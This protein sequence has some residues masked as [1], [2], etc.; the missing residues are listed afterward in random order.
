MNRVAD[1]SIPIEALVEDPV[2]AVERMAEAE[3]SLG[4]SHP[5]IAEPSSLYGAGRRNS[6]GLD[7]SNE[8]T[9]QSL[10]LALTESAGVRWTAQPMLS[11]AAPMVDAGWKPVRN[12]ANHLDIVGRCRAATE[13]EIESALK[14]ATEFAPSWAATSPAGRADCLERAA[15]LM[16]ARMPLL[17]GL[18]AREAGKTYSNGIA[19]VREAIDF[20]RF[21]AAQARNDFDNHAH[22]ALGPVVCISPWNFPLAIFVGQIAAAAAAGNTVLAKPAEQTSLIAAAGIGLLRE[23]GVPPAAVQLVTGRG[24][25]VG[26]RMIADART[27]GVMFTGST[28]VARHLQQTLAGRVGPTGDPIPLIAETGGQNAMLVDSS[29]LLEQVAADIVGSAFDSAGQRCSALRV[30]C[31]QDEIADSLIAM[32]RGEMAESDVGNPAMLRTDVGPVI[33]AGARRGIEDHIE[34]MRAKGR[35]VHRLGRH[36]R[37]VIEGGTYVLPT[38]IEL[39]SISELTKEVFG[40]V[41]HVVRFSRQNLLAMLDQVN[42][43]GYGLTMGLHTRIDETIERVVARARAGNLYINRNMVGAVVGVQPFGGEGLSGTGPKAGGPLYMYRLIAAT[44]QDVL[45]RALAV[46][47]PGSQPV[48]MNRRTPEV[49]GSLL[50][51]L[52]EHQAHR[53]AAQCR[54]FADLVGDCSERVLAGPTGERNV[55]SLHPRE[56]VFCMADST[57]GYLHALAAALAVGTQVIWEASSTTEALRANLPP[58]VQK[59]IVLAKDWLSSNVAFDVALHQGSESELKRVSALLARR[60]GPIVSLRRFSAEQASMPLEALMVERAISTNTTA[61]GG[62]ASLMTIA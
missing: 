62:N 1:P 11:Q 27:Q 38:L 36:A 57:D 40:P 8:Q 37:A 23:G 26:A 48:Q 4:L 14:S 29:A 22:R 47:L 33:D 13:D 58:D 60:D 55:Y 18:L 17:L 30:L 44:P 41:L 7:L 16:Q 45:S 61:A 31:V 20:L 32:V 50:A 34:A 28:E 25:V 6:Q 43:T 35:K 42:A 2:E 39:E 56:A 15:D 49:F 51:W 21:Y 52:A 19:E 10:E 12:P 3:G 54:K 46:G 53:T 9:L 59:R 5:L 24:S